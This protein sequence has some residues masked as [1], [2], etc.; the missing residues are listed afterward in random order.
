MAA[1]N[2]KRHNRR[3]KLAT[4]ARKRADD[5]RASYAPVDLYNELKAL[6]VDPRDYRLDNPN[7]K[8]HSDRDIVPTLGLSPDP[9]NWNHNHEDTKF[10]EQRNYK[11]LRKPLTATA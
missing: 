3:M 9:R 11:P 10:F 7:E 1:L 8:H 5:R 6:G 4:E 2:M